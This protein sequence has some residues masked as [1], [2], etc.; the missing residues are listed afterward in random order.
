[1]GREVLLKNKQSQRKLERRVDKLGK[2]QRGQGEQFRAMGKTIQGKRRYKP[3]QGKQR[4][5]LR[6]KTG[7]I[8]KGAGKD[9]ASKIEEKEKDANGRACQRFRAKRFKR[10]EGKLFF[11]KAVKAE[12]QRKTQ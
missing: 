12:S 4:P 8:A 10:R 7:Q 1:M 3:A 2:T 5:C 6:G 9:G 11:K